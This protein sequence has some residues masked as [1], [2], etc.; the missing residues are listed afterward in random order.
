M[1]FTFTGLK[2]KGYIGKFGA[3]EMSDISAFEVFP[4][5]K[6]LSGSESG[7][8]LLWDAHFIKA[9]LHTPGMKPCHE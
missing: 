7:H 9:V 8:L 6:V 1:A 5:E 2:L 3:V 4:D